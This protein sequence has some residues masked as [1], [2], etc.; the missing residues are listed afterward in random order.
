MFHTGR[1]HLVSD[2]GSWNDYEV[3]N[4]HL[5]LVGKER[6][7]QANA[8]CGDGWLDHPDCR[9]G[10]RILCGDLNATSRSGV[11]RLLGETLRDAQ[12]LVGKNRSTWPSF[13]PLVRYD[14][15]FV[16][17]RIQVLRAEPLKTPLT[18]IA[19]DHLP[20]LVEFKVLDN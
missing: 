10:P 14:H 18:R 2:L 4:T 16:C 12:A 17:P 19:S 6:V 15:V 7:L 11:C 13:L 9:Q 3:I 5:G 20:V 1:S 8:L